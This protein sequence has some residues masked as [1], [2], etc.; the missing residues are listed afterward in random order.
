MKRKKKDKTVLNLLSKTKQ[1]IGGLDKF[2]YILLIIFLVISLLFNFSIKF[3][4]IL[5]IIFLILVIIIYALKIKYKNI[6]DFDYDID[7]IEIEDLKLIIINYYK[8]LEYKIDE[9]RKISSYRKK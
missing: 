2:V 4:T 9:S 6:N 1:Y 5:S 7:N 3:T 8:N